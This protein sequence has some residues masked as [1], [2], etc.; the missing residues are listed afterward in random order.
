MR[1]LHVSDLHLGKTIHGV[2]MMENGD[3]PHWVERFLG[4]VA[5]R[6]PDAVLVSGDVYDRGAPSASAM[7]LWGHLVD[8]LVDMGICTLV[9][10]GNHDSGRRLSCARDTLARNAVHIAGPVGSELGHVTLTDEFG[11]VTFWLMP[12]VFPAAVAR[13]LGDPSIRDYEVAIRRLLAEQDMDVSARNVLLAHQ[14]VTAFGKEVERGGSESMV[15]GVGQVDFATFDAF[16]YVALGHIHS[17]YSV[18]RPEVRYAGSPLCYH[19]QETRQSQKGP[20]LVELGAKG[21]PVHMETL[22]IAPLHPMREMRGKAEELKEAELGRQSR[23]EYLRLVVTDQPLTPDLCD[24]F[25]GLAESRGSI[26][27]ERVSEFRQFA[28]A[29]SSDLELPAA[30]AK[31]TE[32]LFADFYVERSGGE[33]LDE[34]DAALL[35]EAF[36]Q[37]RDNAPE[38]EHR[39]DVSDGL[40]EGLLGFLLRQEDAS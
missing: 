4:L 2:S 27:M 26:L 10:P 11:P 24:F 13:A 29:G 33:A 28:G 34:G 39:S 21:S 31:T 7:E 16:D 30:Q 37:L 23:G 6:R 22:E 18:G 15:G 14:N 5:E 20:V 32:E 12:Y 8:S 35:H 17:S 36:R 3:Q 1:L 9:I 25:K 19:F 40:V 38:T